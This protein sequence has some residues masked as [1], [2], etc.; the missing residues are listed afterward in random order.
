MNLIGYH[1]SIQGIRKG[2]F[3]RENGILKGEEL[4]LE[5]EPP[6]LNSC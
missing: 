2:Y 4:D 3:F 1:L 6:R 5:A